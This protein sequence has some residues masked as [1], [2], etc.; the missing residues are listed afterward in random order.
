MSWPEIIILLS[1]GFAVGF[2]NTFA[3]G[4]TVISLAVLMVM[5]LPIAVANATH[6]VAAM[7]QTAASS[8]AFFR[9]KMLDL[10]TGL[11]LGVPATIGSVI[12]AFLAVDIT[13]KTFELFAIFAM[14]MMLAAMLVKPSLWLEGRK[15]EPALEPKR[16]HYALFFLIGL[17]G[18]FIYIGIGYV[19]LAGLVLGTGFDLIRSNALKVFIVMLYVPFTLLPFILNDMIHWHYALVL[20]AGQAAGAFIAARFTLKTNTGFIRWFMIA[21]IVIALAELLNIINLQSWLNIG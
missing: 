1:A 9:Q 16:W 2:I 18:G 19:L 7:F 15:K 8:G 12:G 5:G 11:K 20:S 13:E 21:F 3:G 4:A 17:Y 14:V 10:R 6:R